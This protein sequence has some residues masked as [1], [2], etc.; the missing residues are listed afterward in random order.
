M[1][2]PSGPS[3][4]NS[5]PGGSGQPKKNNGTP[6][7]KP[8]TP[9]R[10]REPGNT[11][12]GA[13]PGVP[14]GTPAGAGTAAGKAAGAAGPASSAAGGALGKV[15]P[16][17]G[18]IGD[19]AQAAKA[20]KDG[21]ALGAADAGVRAGAKAGAEALAPGVGGTVAGAVLDTWIGR[22]ATRL[23]SYGI[24]AQVVVI[25]LVPVLVIAL[26][27]SLF[28]GRMTTDQ[29][30]LT[31]ECTIIMDTN[32]VPS[33]QDPSQ[34][35]VAATI[36]AQARGLGLGEVAA[37][38]GIFV[39]YAESSLQ[40]R[41]YGDDDG[42]YMSQS[43]GAFQQKA[44]WAPPGNA[45]SGKNWTP[46]T[47]RPKFS[48][49]HAWTLEDKELGIERGWAWDDVRMNVAQAANLFFLGPAYNKKEGLEDFKEFARNY[50][51]QA[52]QVSDRDYALM[53]ANVQKYNM[54]YAD[55]YNSKIAEAR[56]ILK[57]IKEGEIAV[58]QYV[59][60]TPEIAKHAT[61]KW[62][63]G[64]VGN[65]IAVQGPGDDVGSGQ[66][67]VGL[68]LIGDSIMQRM[69]SYAQVPGSY[70]GGPVT[71]DYLVGVSLRNVLTGKIV[72]APAL[73]GGA[74][75]MRK[76]RE[77][78]KT[79]TSPIVVS[80]GANNPGTTFE[81]DVAR[82]MKLAGARDVYWMTWAFDADGKY[83]RQLKSA[84][85]R[86]PNLKIIDVRTT[87]RSTDGYMADKVHQ[88]KSGSQFM[89]SKIK[90]T[91]VADGF[92]SAPADGTAAITR[93]LAVN[94]QGYTSYITLSGDGSLGARAVQVA[95]SMFE[96]NAQYDPS[97][98]GRPPATTDCSKTTAYA[99]KMAGGPNLVPLSWGQYQDRK[100]IVFVPLD[101]ARPGDLLFFYTGSGLGS[102]NPISH[103]GMVLNPDEKTMI[104]AANSRVDM[105]ISNYMTYQYPVAG[106]PDRNGRPTWGTPVA[107]RVIA[108]TDTQ[109]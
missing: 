1:A 75:D 41:T 19:V 12:R 88:S 23:V 97:G 15:G 77:R 89:W 101:Q 62:T 40:N 72:S 20:A 28:A 4:G 9:R 24:I 87:L 29:Q 17:G 26:A 104:H 32:A 3:G 108:P 96:A 70:N 25:L 65:V 67:A 6:V 52:S 31:G 69:I 107:G 81:A 46:E 54:K 61:S 7:P 103:V 64:L 55:I 78:L 86:F 11:S 47:S 14:K 94:C 105:V 43:R 102:S 5:Q 74:A 99:Y 85:T 80:L 100:N 109:A 60:P 92:T 59:P 66:S 30:L 21:D 33:A 71:K 45:W 42:P 49:P 38:A 76:W 51:K 91:L 68:H 53:G 57:R 56:K 18:A 84:A 10:V 34:D 98:N 27:G 106:P 93:N 36:Y 63:D 37:L 39:S 8:G 58:P 79:G 22:K 95:M 16:A 35:E 83:A 13:A 48:T 82:F 50:G 2:T 44:G 73:T 90:S